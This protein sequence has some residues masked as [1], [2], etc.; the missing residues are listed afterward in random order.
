MA[1]IY[2]KQKLRVFDRDATKKKQKS[3]YRLWAMAICFILR[4]SKKK[5]SFDQWLF[6]ERNGY[7]AFIAH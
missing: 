1:I 7:I 4:V 6:C 3:F 2:Y 5:A